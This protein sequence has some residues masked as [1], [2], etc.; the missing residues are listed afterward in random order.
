[1][2]LLPSLHC[3]ALEK[4]QQQPA[5][6]EKQQQQTGEKEVMAS[7]ELSPVVPWPLSFLFPLPFSLC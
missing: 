1:M 5:A 2:L 4:Q 6:L 7:L 3:A